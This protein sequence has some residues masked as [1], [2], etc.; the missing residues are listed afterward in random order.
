MVVKQ[1]IHEH[2]MGKSRADK[3][4]CIEILKNPMNYTIIICAKSINITFLTNDSMYPSNDHTIYSV[5]PFA[6]N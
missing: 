4:A 5:L 3:E 2:K 1:L 6:T